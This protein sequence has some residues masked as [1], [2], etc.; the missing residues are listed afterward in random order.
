MKITAIKTEKVT[1]NSE[2]TLTA[3]LDRSLDSF[4]EN[5][6]LVITS[7]IVSLLE[8]RVFEKNHE[9]KEGFIESES[10]YYLEAEESKYGIP[11][12]IRDNTFLARA[13]IDG[14]NTNGVN[15]LL[16]KDS[17]QTA[18]AV[19]TYLRER[20]DIKNVGVIIT[21]SHSLALRRGTTGITIGWSGF[22]A[23]KAYEHEKDVFGHT[24]SSH[25]NL[26]DSLAGAAVAEMGEGN[27]QTPLVLISDIKNIEWSEQSP[28]A[29][30][31]AFFFP[32]FEDD[33][34]A[35]LF[36]F[37]KLKKGKRSKA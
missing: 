14:A 15:V 11:L 25:L 12:T 36:N 37:S 7:K 5:S 18:K 20:F 29:E 33:L 32:S 10:D 16:P 9:D 4:A 6:V 8:K 28:T 22:K 23:I 26:V 3:F 35:P 31:T 24:F 30:E 17:Y 13:G 21:D 1:G 34:F 27:E 19:C 2:S